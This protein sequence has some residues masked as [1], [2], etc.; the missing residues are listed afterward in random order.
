[1]RWLQHASLLALLILFVADSASAQAA[2]EYA[3]AV[4][5]M[6]AA[7]TQAQAEAA[8]KI[9]FPPSPQKKSQSSHLGAQ[10]LRAQTMDKP[11][12][13]TNRLVLEQRAGKNA[14]KL[15]LRSVPNRA[16]VWID[17][18]RI[19]STPLL[20]ILAPGKYKV[21]MEGSRKAFAQKQVDLQPQERQEVV[22]NLEQRY[23][24]H[25]RLR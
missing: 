16:Q 7:G 19:G 15:L 2:A 20:L 1:M 3:G 9:V 13:A 18:K 11:L 10:T 14:G 23:P 4:S 22:L 17:G 21:K 25:L 8:K 24:S 5:T 12:E 6:G